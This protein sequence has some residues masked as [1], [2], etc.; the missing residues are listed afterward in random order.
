MRTY[1]CTNTNILT[2]ENSLNLQKYCGWT[3]TE[4]NELKNLWNKKYNKKY[5]NG[6]CTKTKCLE[7]LG[8]ELFI[9][10]NKIDKK[11]CKKIRQSG[12]IRMKLIKLGLLNSNNNNNNNLEIENET[13]TQP[14]KKQ[15][16]N[17]GK[18]K[19]IHA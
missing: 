7:K 8:N 1:P 15:R 18:S 12:G 9:K 3:K 5:Y 11:Y 17:N 13:E 14:K 10:C 2:E 19:N 4:E 16:L 6:N